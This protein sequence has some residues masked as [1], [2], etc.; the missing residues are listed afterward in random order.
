MVSRL[1]GLLLELS[2]YYA[3][4]GGNCCVLNASGKTFNYFGIFWNISFI[5]EFMIIPE[6]ETLK[7]SSLNTSTY[8]AQKLQIFSK[9]L[10]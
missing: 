4:P 7:Q 10:T 5:A 9:S 1:L 3:C 2:Q 8:I 6:Q